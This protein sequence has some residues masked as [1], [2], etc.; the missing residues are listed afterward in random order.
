MNCKH[1]NVDKD[2][3]MFYKDKSKPSGYKPRCKPCDLLSV[4]VERRKK[5]ESE[6]WSDSE[7][8]IKK[9]ATVKKSMLKNAEHHKEVRR[10]YLKTD[11]GIA[12][13]RKQT[14]KRY[15]LK[16]LAFIED[17]SPL[18]LFNEQSGICYLC[19]KSFLFK[20]M[21]LDHVHPIVKG[22]LHKKT[23]CKMACRRC[24]RSKGSKSLE[25]MIYQVD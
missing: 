9:K 25:E 11:K 14:Q 13:Y 18:D 16:K 10:K 8:K 4:D 19:Q 20:E 2:E 5:Y 22:G 1:C 24:N 12:M 6:Y 23:N 7:R 21:E 3:S 17:V 15:A